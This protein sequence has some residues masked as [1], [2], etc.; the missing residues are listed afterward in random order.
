[1]R[2]LRRDAHLSGKELAAVCG[3]HPSKVSRIEWAKQQPTEDDLLA[4]CRAV[5]KQAAYDDLVAA[6]RNLRSMYLEWRRITAGGHAPRQRRSI[7][8]ESVVKGLRWHEVNVIPGLLQTAD[9]ARGILRA[10][11]DM[12]GGRNDLD[13]A[14][15]VRMARKKVLHSGARRFTFLIEAAAL[16][17]TVA[18]PEVMVTQMDTLLDASHNPR[19]SLGII[20]LTALYRCPAR[21]FIVF[22]DA[23]VMVE[24]PSAELT[25][26]SPSEIRTYERTFELLAKSAVFGD[27]ARDLIAEAR[28]VHAGS[29]DMGD[30]TI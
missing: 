15:A 27:S 18:S 19:V 8:I 30:G 7:E 9:Y 20:P 17:R 29:L 5:G 25:V 12:T 3:W 24:T 10:C 28:S 6:L 22:D 1:M 13:D 14:V 26:T 4:W 21:G 16:Y 23:M 11:I 2:E